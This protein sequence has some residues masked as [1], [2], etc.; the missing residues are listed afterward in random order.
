MRTKQIATFRR[1]ALAAV[2]LCAWGATPPASAAAQEN[3]PVVLAP[4]SQPS[5]LVSGTG[6]VTLTP[7]IAR[8]TVGV[9]TRGKE[10]AQAANENARLSAAVIKAI[11]GAGVTDKDI[12][13]TDYNITPQFDYQKQPAVLTDYLVSNL[14][15]VTVRKM[16]DAGRILDAANKAG[17][18]ISG[19]IS[20]AASDPQKARDEALARAVSDATRKA[21][22]MWRAAPLD[23]QFRRGNR[24]RLI[25]LTEM[26]V[27]GYPPPMPMARAAMADTAL[28]NT[29]I[30]AGETKI[31]ITVSA[32]FTYDDGR[33]AI[34]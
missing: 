5:I 10:S 22:V 20:F 34:K 24:L 18:N 17:A 19:G 3:R 23:E 14:L 16:G 1:T 4:L 6:E 27:G 32:R 12:Q 9:Q 21:N 8:F 29:P 7:D 25:E 28:S 31:V 2:A 13:T 11:K 30:Q 26:N 15:Q 33:G